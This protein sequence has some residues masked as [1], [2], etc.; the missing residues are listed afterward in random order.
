MGQWLSEL[1]NRGRAKATRNHETPAPGGACTATYRVV[2]QWPGG[3]VAQVDVKAGQPLSGWV[4]QVTLANGAT[5]SNTWNGVQSG[6]SQ[7][8]TVRNAPWNGN[9]AA[10]QSTSFGFQG[11][12]TGAGATVTCQAA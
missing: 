6:P 8:P 9:V 12:G 4:V 3:F 2:D 7:A 10:G 5:A 11:V 1:S